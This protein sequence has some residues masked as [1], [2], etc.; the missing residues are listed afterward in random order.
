MNAREHKL[1]FFVL[2]L[3]GLGAHAQDPPARKIDPSSTLTV[4]AY[5]AGLF[6]FA[7]HDHVIAAP[8]ASGEVVLS[9]TAPRVRL[10]V[11]AVGMKVLDPQLDADKR[12]DVQKTMHS[13][14]V[15]DTARFPQI[16]FTSTQIR[17]IS[18]GH[19]QVTGDLEL[20]GSTRP[21]TFEVVERDGAYAGEARLKQSTHGITPISLAGG[22]IKVKDEVKIEFAVRLQ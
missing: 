9:D 16:A 22:A 1:R 14:K 13:S 11:N 5:K 19:W 15:L 3:L 4:Y 10:V 17:R 8:I 2:L 12:A 6:S 21:I 7:A 20:H 18:A